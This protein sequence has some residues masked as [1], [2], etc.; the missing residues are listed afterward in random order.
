MSYAI[1]I[2]VSGDPIYAPLAV[3]AVRDLEGLPQ[4]PGEEITAVM[5]AMESLL[6]ALLGN[7]A[8]E[9]EPA[10]LRMRLEADETLLSILLGLRPADGG[11]EPATPLGDRQEEI[12]EQLRAAFDDVEGPAGTAPFRLV[13]TRRFGG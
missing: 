2:T 11:Q 9:P 3:R 5:P 13:L 12:L 10:S 6:A 1:E 8:R 7:L 4:G